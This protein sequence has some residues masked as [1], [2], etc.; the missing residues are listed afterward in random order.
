MNIKVDFKTKG[1]KRY[2]EGNFEVTKGPVHQ[3]STEYGLTY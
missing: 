3:E 2:K 1:T